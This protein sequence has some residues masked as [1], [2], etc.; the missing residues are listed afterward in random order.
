MPDGRLND[1]TMRFNLRKEE[2]S[3]TGAIL[4]K[5]Y[6]ALKEKGYNPVDQIVGYLISGDPAYITSYRDARTMIRKI[7]R[8]EIIEELLRTY[9]QE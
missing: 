4:K 6:Q 7:D 8:D 5:V 2:L 1:E 3:E 9:L